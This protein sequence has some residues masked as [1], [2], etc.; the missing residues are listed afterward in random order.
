MNRI[1]R[2]LKLNVDIVSTNETFAKVKEYFELK[3]SGAILSHTEIESHDDLLKHLPKNPEHLLTFMIMA[4][5][6]SISAG[7]GI[8]ALAAK[9][10]KLMDNFDRVIVYPAQQASDT[11]FGTYDDMNAGPL[12]AGVETLQRLGKEVGGIFKKSETEN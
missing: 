7:T 11:V 5:K 1:S 2:E 3:E 9:M 6:G 10:A 12:A 4:R 8:E